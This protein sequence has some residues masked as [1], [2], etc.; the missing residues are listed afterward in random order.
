MDDL[1]T[2][3]KYCIT[4]I[5]DV[6]NYKIINAAIKTLREGLPSFS[7]NLLVRT[8]EFF[9]K[10]VVLIHH[11]N[12]EVKEN[13]SEL[14]ERYIENLAEKLEE[15]ENR[16]KRIFNTIM[17][18]FFEFLSGRDTDLFVLTVVIRTVGIFAKAIA[19]IRGS[20]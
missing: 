11:S 12:K 18:K 7:A 14:F 9:Q 8:E 16:H 19:K 3:L 10:L 6:S 4:P 1:F 20:S 15:D 17:D 13:A 2:C 5:P